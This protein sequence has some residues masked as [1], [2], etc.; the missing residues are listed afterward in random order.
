MRSIIGTSG[1]G[2]VCTGL[3]FLSSSS[4]GQAAVTEWS[5]VAKTTNAACGDGFVVE[6]VEQPGTAKLTFFFFG[7]R[8]P[9]RPSIYQPMEVAKSKLPVSLAEWFMRSLPVPANDQSS[10]SRSRAFVDGPGSQADLP[11]DW[12]AAGPLRSAVVNGGSSR[13]P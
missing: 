4:F 12:L 8:R 5:S 3:L 1:V 10:R 11:P 13:G 6:V 7:G 2:L 9:K